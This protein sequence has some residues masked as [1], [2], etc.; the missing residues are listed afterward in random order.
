M[1]LEYTKNQRPKTSAHRLDAG[2]G[3]GVASDDP[4]LRALMSALGTGDGL[5]LPPDQMSSAAAVAAGT[6]AN[7]PATIDIVT[8]MRGRIPPA[9]T[10]TTEDV[11]MVQAP[12]LSVHTATTI[13]A[14]VDTATKASVIPT[15]APSSISQPQ[16]QPQPATHTTSY[17]TL[18]ATATQARTNGPPA[19]PPT[20]ITIPTPPTSMRAPNA[21]TMPTAVV[22]VQSAWLLHLELSCALVELVL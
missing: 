12:P 17:A 7:I 18:S 6:S 13:A 14:T 9:S 11:V 22:W 5:R 4:Q 16:P 3:D 8:E 19:P 1:N 20:A 21:A 10:T 2:N 15:I